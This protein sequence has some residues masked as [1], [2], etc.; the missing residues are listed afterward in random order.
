ML[1][2]A[3]VMALA[4]GTVQRLT[5]DAPSLRENRRSVRVYLPP[6]Y[7]QPTARGRRYPVVYLLHGWPG[8]EGNWFGLGRA[9]ETADSLIADGVIPEL[10]LVCPHGG[11]PGLLGRSLYINSADGSS[12]MEDFLARDLVRWTDST[13]RTRPERAARAIAGLSDGGGAAVNLAFKHPDVF[14]GCASMSGE[15]TLAGGMGTGRLLGSGPARVRLLAENSP[16]RY[17]TRIA[18]RLQGVTIYFDCGLADEQLG[19]NRVF[20]RTLERLGIRHV[21][22]EFP[23]THTW[24]Y[25]R[26]HLR[27]VLIALAMSRAGDRAVDF[28]VRSP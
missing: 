20:H 15:F 10:I 11:G 27:D 16:Q 23:G 3:L 9:A 1:S 14:G 17:V 22:R 24:G 7:F 8:S 28:R 19:D 12:R 6:S 5:L 4:T 13:F 21:Y 18:S 2:L 26:T 25:W